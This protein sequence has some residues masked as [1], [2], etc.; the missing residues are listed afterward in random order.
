M[1]SLPLVLVG[2]IW[3]QLHFREFFATGKR[4]CSGW[5]HL[6]IPWSRLDF[7]ALG[8]LP[9]HTQIIGHACPGVAEVRANRFFGHPIGFIDTVL[10][11]PRLKRLE[12]S[13]CDGVIDRIL[14][15]ERT[16]PHLEPSVGCLILHC[17]FSLDGFGCLL[18]FL[19]ESSR[20][21]GPL[22]DTRLELDFCQ[23]Y[24]LDDYQLTAL[25]QTWKA[26]NVQCLRLSNN[27]GLFVLAPVRLARFDLLTLDVACC[28]LF[29]DSALHEIALLPAL[30]ELD[31]SYCDLVSD[32][33]LAYLG[34][35]KHLMSVKLTGLGAISDAGLRSLPRQIQILFVDGCAQ[36][37]SHARALAPTA[38]TP[39]VAVGAS[40]LQ[41]TWI[42]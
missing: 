10:V 8:S 13:C 5:Q 38:R 23:Q 6:Q 27:G 2:L 26:R 31:L 11:M 35:L 41:F 36:E 24:N 21:C 40:A 4:V 32:A 42:L 9:N 34:P 15:F 29:G 18:E 22:G 17:L 28:C 19:D 30:R 39:V 16:N 7:V 20:S 37:L 25:A 12:L 3:A 1:E 14:G 33:G